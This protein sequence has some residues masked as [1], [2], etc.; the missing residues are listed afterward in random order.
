METF[1][2]K[3]SHM[4]SPLWVNN[5]SDFA[6]ICQDTKVCNQNSEISKNAWNVAISFAKLTSDV[7]THTYTNCTTV[8]VLK[9]SKKHTH[10][11]ILWISCVS[12]GCC[13]IKKII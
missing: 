12:Q 4:M 5:V 2:E 3:Y 11:N 1:A 6:E 10:F 7:H 8:N 13:G 9:A